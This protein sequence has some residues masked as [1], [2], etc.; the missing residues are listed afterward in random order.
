MS[1]KNTEICLALLCA[2]LLAPTAG[3][4]AAPTKNLGSEKLDKA[5]YSFPVQNLHLSGNTVSFTIPENANT[6][7]KKADAVRLSGLYAT[8]QERAAT[9][10]VIDSHYVDKKVKK[11]N[12]VSGKA[13][14]IATFEDPLDA[15]KAAHNGCLL[16]YDQD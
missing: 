2:S 16:I 12:P 8:D 15:A 3:A 9:C 14:V 11:Y 13:E 5:A 10:P 1:R 4:L 6:H 7:N